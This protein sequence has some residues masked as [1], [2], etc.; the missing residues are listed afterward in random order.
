MFGVEPAEVGFTPPDGE[1]EGGQTEVRLGLATA[2]GEPEEVGQ[3]SVVVGALRVA[4]VCERGQVQQQ[5]G[6]LEGAPAAVLRQV[7]RL[8]RVLEGHRGSA[9]P[10]A[11]GDGVDALVPHGAVGEPEGVQGFRI[12]PQQVD[13]GLDPVR[14]PPGEAHVLRGLGPVRVKFGGRVVHR[15]LLPLDPGAVAVHQ[16][17]QRD[18]QGVGF[19]PAQL[20]HVQ[21]EF[22]QF[23]QVLVPLVSARVRYVGVRHL[24]RRRGGGGD[25]DGPSPIGRGGLGVYAG[26]VADGELGMEAVRHGERASLP[27]IA[28]GRFDGTARQEGRGVR[29]S[30]D[31]HRRLEHPVGRTGPVLLPVDE[32]QGHQPRTLVQTCPPAHH[33]VREVLGMQRLCRQFALHQFHSDAARAG[34]A[35]EHPLRVALDLR[36]TSLVPCPCAVDRQFLSSLVHP[37]GQTQGRRVEAG[38]VGRGR[39]RIPGLRLLLGR[40]ALFVERFGRDL[41]ADGAQGGPAFVPHTAGGQPPDDVV[42]QRVP[43]QLLRLVAGGPEQVAHDELC[44]PVAQLLWF[45][46]GQNRVGRIRPGAGGGKGILGHGARVGGATDNRYGLRPGKPITRRITPSDGPLSAGSRSRPLAAS[47]ML[48]TLRALRDATRRTAWRCGGAEGERGV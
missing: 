25:A 39:F 19:H 9:S 45:G 2:G 37:H 4:G 14:C 21:N 28:P 18:P 31:G 24:V 16:R 1:G 5:E 34:H 3:R 47:V 11:C 46:R 38:H 22:G 15:L 29:R 48:V 35:V 30:R 40:H 17:K 13:A 12:V 32:E 8:D 20:A 43:R 6:Q 36:V 33:D 44:E 42:V 10:T 27:L 26:A 23:R 41:L 7:G